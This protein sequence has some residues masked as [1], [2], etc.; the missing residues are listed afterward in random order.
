MAIQPRTW[1]VCLLLALLSLCP[2]AEASHRVFPDL[3]SLE[4]EAGRAVDVDDSLRTGYHFQPPMHWINGTYVQIKHL[5][6]R[7]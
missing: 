4:A 3:Q 7:H 6:D 5:A 2:V 1:V